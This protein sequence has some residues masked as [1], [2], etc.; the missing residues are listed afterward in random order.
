MLQLAIYHPAIPQ[1]TGNLGRLC[2]GMDAHL[3]IIGPCAFDFS[4]KALRRAGLDYWPHLQW[5]MHDDEQAFERWLD[6]R[7]PWLISKYGQQRY[8]KAS[9]HDDDILILGNENHGLPRTWHQRWPQ[10]TIAIPLRGAI[11]SFNVANAG[12]MVLACASAQCGAFDHWSALPFPDP[13]ATTA[14]AP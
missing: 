3:H 13:P 4:D 8:D 6:G 11:R 12:A 1:N 5:T 2:V 14:P 9:Y 10:R 7:E